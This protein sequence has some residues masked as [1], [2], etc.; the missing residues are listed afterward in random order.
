MR[1]DW[2]RVS[3]ELAGFY[4]DYSNYIFGQKTGNTCDEMGM[5]IAGPARSSTS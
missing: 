2:G 4:L 3:G 5:C 1:G